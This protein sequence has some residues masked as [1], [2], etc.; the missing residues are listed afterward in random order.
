MSDNVLFMDEVKVL[1]RLSEPTIN[2]YVKERG[3]PKPSKVGPRNAWWKS[4]I[5]SWIESQMNG[6]KK[7]GE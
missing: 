4:D 1:T 7:A 6:T 3:F 5:E 2:K